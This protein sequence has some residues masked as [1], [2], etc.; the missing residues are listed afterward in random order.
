M[1]ES[2]DSVTLHSTTCS[3]TSLSAQVEYWRCAIVGESYGLAGLMGV[4]IEYE[5]LYLALVMSCPMAVPFMHAQV[6]AS[7]GRGGEMIQEFSAAQLARVPTSK[8][9]AQ[10]YQEACGAC[11]SMM[12]ICV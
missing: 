11:H 5:V 9:V 2:S 3:N 4:L 8:G 10:A 12:C 1:N 6:D 7:Q